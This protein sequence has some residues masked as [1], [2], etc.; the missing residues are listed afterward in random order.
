LPSLLMSP[1][2]IVF[3]FAVSSFFA[4]SGPKRRRRLDRDLHKP[5]LTPPSYH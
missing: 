5:C 4:T 1:C 3:L 2:W